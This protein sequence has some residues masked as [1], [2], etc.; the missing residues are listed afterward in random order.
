MA[1]VCC[2]K[3]KGWL[4]LHALLSQE[5]HMHLS[6]L[7]SCY[8]AKLILLT[9][10]LILLFTNVSHRESYFQCFLCISR[11]SIDSGTGILLAVIIIYQYFEIFVM[12]ITVHTNCNDCP[13]ETSDHWR[14]CSHQKTNIATSP[15]FC[16][17]GFLLLCTESFQPC[18]E[19]VR[20]CLGLI[21][22]E[23][24]GLIAHSLIFFL[25]I[26]LHLL[27]VICINHFQTMLN[28]RKVETFQPYGLNNNK[29]VN[30]TW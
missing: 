6:L 17:K 10:E 1:S 14:V 13:C 23:I 28:R 20:G 5:S 2:S 27:K 24:P 29:Q 12:T 4:Y 16:L 15:R 25:F 11:F 7:T 8:H 21:T 26:F 3:S 18:P 19:D 22:K 30:T 9:G